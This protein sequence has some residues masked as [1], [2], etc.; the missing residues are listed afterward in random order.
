MK[1][2]ILQ[3]IS[4]GRSSLE[5]GDIVKTKDHITK[6]IEYL[7]SY[8]PSPEEHNEIQI[9]L[10]EFL[11]IRQVALWKGKGIAEYD[12]LK[13]SSNQE[14]TDSNKELYKDLERLLG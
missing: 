8:V 7:K 2:Y 10:K 12:V 11:L 6:V 9:F 1:S 5:K 3:E 13:K 14:I 4:F